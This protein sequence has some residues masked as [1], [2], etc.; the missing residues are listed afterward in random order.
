MFTLL[1]AAVAT[2]SVKSVAILAAAGAAGYAVGSKSN[3]K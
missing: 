2:I 3:D 1:A